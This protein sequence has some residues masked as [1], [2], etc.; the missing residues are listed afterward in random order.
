[1]EPVAVV[2]NQQ[3]EK[4]QLLLMKMHHK[5]SYCPLWDKLGNVDAWMLSPQVN[6]SRYIYIYIYSTKY[7]HR[8][9]KLDI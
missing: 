4:T 8:L 7:S 9:E 2:I 1:M 6:A 5:W 3:K